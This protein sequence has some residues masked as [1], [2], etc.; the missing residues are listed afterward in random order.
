MFDRYEPGPMPV[1]AERHQTMTE[2]QGKDGPNAL[3]TWKQGDL[4][5]VDEYTDD[6]LHRLDAFGPSGRF[7]FACWCPNDH[8][9]DSV[10]EIEDGRWVRTT[11]A[12]DG[13]AAGPRILQ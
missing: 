9:T 8:R 1:C 10:G 3:L 5:P 7:S 11:P 13:E 4:L 12:S 6:P 2:C